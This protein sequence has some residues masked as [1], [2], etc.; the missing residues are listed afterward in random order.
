MASSSYQQSS[1][2]GTRLISELSTCHLMKVPSLVQF[3]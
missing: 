3:I 1:G 2:L